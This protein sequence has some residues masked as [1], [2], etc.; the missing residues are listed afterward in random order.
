[1]KQLI[2][3]MVIAMLFSTITLAMA[4]EHPG[5]INLN[6]ATQEQLVASGLSEELSTA[7]L[8]LRTENDEFIDMDEIMDVDGMDAKTLRMI[9]KSF[10]I[11]EVAGCNC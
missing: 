8:E 4:N 7:I 3:T 6:Q 1:M 5:M 11:E 2:A 10:Y 9:K